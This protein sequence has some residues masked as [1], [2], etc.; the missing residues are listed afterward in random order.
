[1]ATKRHT[2]PE[3]ATAA[4]RRPTATPWAGNYDDN[5]FY[6]VVG[7]GMPSPYVVATGGEGDADKA[8]VALIVRAVN[9]HQDLVDALQDWLY[10]AEETLREF[11]IATCDGEV[12]CPK[13]EAAGCITRKIENARAALTKAGA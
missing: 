10:F 1:M 2:A 11:T 7:E 9:A 5:G 8:N 3:G 13:C 12:L 6:Y 4:L